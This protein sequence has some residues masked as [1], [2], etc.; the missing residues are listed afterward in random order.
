MRGAKA[1]LGAQQFYTLSP[2]SQADG[3][4]IFVNI[5]GKPADEFV[6][7]LVVAVDRLPLAI[8]LL[9]NLT[10]GDN[11]TTEAVW[12]RWQKKG[13]SV[14]SRGDTENS[15]LMSLNASIE[16]SL[17]SPRLQ[18]DQSARATLAMLALLP[19]GIKNPSQLFED[20][21]HFLPE[22]IDLSESL[23]K[24]ARVALAYRDNARSERYRL[25]SPI[26]QYIRSRSDSES[27]IF[28]PD[29]MTFIRT[30][31]TM[32]NSGW[33]YS[34]PRMHN[35]IPDE[36]LN[37]YAVLQYTLEQKHSMTSELDVSDLVNACITHTDWMVH[38]GTPTTELISKA[39]SLVSENEQLEGDCHR[40]LASV[41]D[42]I[43][44]LYN[45]E[46]ALVRAVEL[47]QQAHDVIGEGDDIKHVGELYLL[48]NRLEE[49]ETSLLRAVEPHR[50][51]HSV[52]DEGSDLARLGELYIRL[53]R[54]DEAESSLLQAVEL[55]QKAHAAFSEGSDMTSLG[56]LY[57]QLDRL[58]EAETSLL[59]AVELHQQAH[60]VL[61]EGTDN[62]R[63]SELYMRLDRL[64]EAEASLLRAVELHRQT[65]SV[66]DEGSDLA[67]LGELYIRLDRL[68]EAE[69]S[70]L[71]AV[72]LHQKAH[73]AFNEGSDMTS[74]GVL[75]MRLNR[76]D[77][78][79]THMLAALK[80][81]RQAGSVYDEGIDMAKLGDIY[82]RYGRLDEAK[83]HSLEA[84]ELCR[85]AHDSGTGRYAEGLLEEVMRRRVSAED[86][87][88]SSG[89]DQEV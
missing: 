84:V 45:A 56:V 30:C 6:D 19:D 89:D 49:A 82:L 37:I 16:L 69:T 38:L 31:T 13:T 5:S 51:T 46:K 76:L 58:D 25:L 73:A 75:Y 44:Q 24:V 17:S 53:D 63:L 9:A 78:A 60:S 50:Q 23:P 41:Y 61:D 14:V 77:D 55:H 83:S 36:L 70:L 65:H 80:L 71:R 74:S 10:K 28:K 62:L 54:L 32:I 81:H 59:R 66:L 29:L 57:M 48:L 18:G 87:E 34:D 26:S 85:P 15:R 47:H 86:D 88:R 2:P 4:A 68:D 22:R 72:E 21:E 52:L 11:E 35:H 27:F 64:D 43:N 79:E 67:R 33:D 42:H 7:K 40:T 20:L 12:K 39:L 3:L 1:P 8:A